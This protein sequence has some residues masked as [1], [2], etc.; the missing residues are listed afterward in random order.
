MKA[1][2]SRPYSLSVQPPPDI[3]L[4]VGD[5]SVR[6]SLFTLDYSAVT[7]PEAGMD[8]SFRLTFE[9]LHASA[10]DVKGE[11]Q[12]IISEAFREIPQGDGSLTHVLHNEDGKI[13]AVRYVMGYSVRPADCLTPTLTSS[14]LFEYPALQWALVIIFAIEEINSNP[15]LLPN[16]TVGY[17]IYDSC[18]A[19]IMALQGLMWQLSA[20]RNPVPNY[21]CAKNSTTVAIIGDALSATS[22]PVAQILGLYRFPQITYAAT[23]PILSDKLIFPSFLR[24]NPNQDFECFGF[25]QLMV[26]FHWNWVGILFQDNNFGRLAGLALKKEMAKT[27]VC[28]DYAETI[29]VHYSESRTLQI[30]DIVK[31]STANV[32]MVFSNPPSLVPLMEEFSRQNIVGKVWVACHCWSEALSLSRKD[33]FNSFMGTLGFAFHSGWIPG[34]KEFFFHANPSTLPG[35]QFIKDF[36]QEAFVCKWETPMIGSTV[37]HDRDPLPCSGSEALGDLSFLS[38]DEFSVRT[39]YNAYIAAYALAH[40]LQNFYSCEPGSG[41]FHNQTCASFDKILPWQ[42]F[43]YMKNVRFKKLSGE[44]VFFD[45]NGEPPVVYDIINWQLSADGNLKYV[46]I[47]TFNYSLDLGPTFQLND[48]AIIWNGDDNSIPQSVC[49]CSCAPGYRK[50]VHR[51]KPVCCYDCIPCPKG[52]TA[53]ETDSPECLK[54]AE[55]YWSNERQD[56]CVLKPLE[57]LSYEEPLGITLAA[58]SIFHSLISLHI[59][60][61]FIK[62]RETPIVKANNRDISYLLLTSLVL[63]FLCPLVFIGYPVRSTCMLRQTA[64]GII[65]AACISCV[66][67]KTITVVFA[68]N[69]TKP[70]SHLK[71]W[72]GSKLATCIIFICTIIQAIICMA[73]LII[74]PPYPDVNTSSKIGVLVIECNEA[75]AVAFWVMLGYMGLLATVSFIV[76]F[77]SRNLPDSFNETKYI[78]FSMLVFVSVWLSFI[79]AYLS[80]K[81]KYMVAVEIFAI[82]SSGFGLLMCIFFPKCYIILLKPEMNTREQLMGKSTFRKSEKTQA[83]V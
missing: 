10:P 3:A 2:K 32:I 8:L 58:F 55:D 49:S 21:R 81:G 56:V 57:F 71:K 16:L 78:T 7:P 27:G 36:W 68:F 1:K 23:I 41:P 48:S 25:A 14:N 73:W 30:V 66:L 75:S 31:K 22:L 77:L 80:T 60:G 24:T 52:E 45:D 4:E 59:L 5:S 42:L 67:A 76:A 69:A 20:Q 44:E 79:P 83:E 9:A 11:P 28:I 47:G 50:V 18:T 53:N 6:Y 82:L 54:C 51:G 37:S 39:A 70:G 15:H 64:F 12:L 72:M 61:I 74:S 19:E 38:F 65:F 13:G 35:N 46:T 33:F 29:P 63:C 34:F 40:S 43:H 62:Y 26:H 17:K